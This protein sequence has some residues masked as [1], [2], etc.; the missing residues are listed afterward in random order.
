[1]FELAS[2]RSS[3]RCIQDLDFSASCTRS[4]PADGLQQL[5][6]SSSRKQATGLALADWRLLMRRT[7]TQGVG[8][9]I[10]SSGFLCWLGLS[11][12]H[13]NTYNP[14]PSTQ[15]FKCAVFMA[16]AAAVSRLFLS[17]QEGS[18]R[19]VWFILQT[20]NHSHAVKGPKPLLCGA[21]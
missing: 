19:Y 20:T 11:Q 13:I 8:K 9:V 17:Q 16:G 12:L 15:P 7:R 18:E 21:L 3:E 6:V 4:L 1:M 14:R 5:L 10:R 2:M